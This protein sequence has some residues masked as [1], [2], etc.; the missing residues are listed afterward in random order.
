MKQLELIPA[1]KE[2][3]TAKEK[4]EIDKIFE[5]YMRWVE[6]TMTTEDNPYIKVI[7]VLRAAT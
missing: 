6:D 1:I 4:R 3:R 2:S 7:A 5:E